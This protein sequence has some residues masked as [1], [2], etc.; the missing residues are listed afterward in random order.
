MK[1]RWTPEV[2]K[3]MLTNPVYAGIGP[4]PAFIEERE[5]V[6]AN[7][8][9]IEEEGAEPIIENILARFQEVFPLLP[10]PDT[11]PYI[12]DA[13]VNP[14]ATLHRLLAALRAIVDTVDEWII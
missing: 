6:E 3:E 5:W 10:L 12:R 8:R 14:S 11:E 2:L 9:L 13:N 7:V 4:Y 1:T